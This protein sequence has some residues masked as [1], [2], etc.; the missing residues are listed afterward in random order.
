MMLSKVKF[1]VAST[2]RVKSLLA[3]L[4]VMVSFAPLEDSG[5]STILAI[6]QFASWSLKSTM[7]LDMS[8]QELHMAIVS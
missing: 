4:I 3:M 2:T 6:V 5:S 1:S 7:L 8:S